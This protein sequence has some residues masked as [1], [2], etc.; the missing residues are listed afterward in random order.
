M[1]LCEGN[2][3]RAARLVQVDRSHLR[4]L[5]RRHQIPAGDSQ[6]HE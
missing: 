1:R 4:D 5:L 6:R 3:S 2:I